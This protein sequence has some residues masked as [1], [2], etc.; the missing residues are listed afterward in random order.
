[1]AVSVML[2]QV[3]ENGYRATALVPTPLVAEAPTRDEAVDRI[4]A[5]ISERLSHAELIR[6]E[7]PLA[8]EPNPWLDMAGTWREHPDV[9]EVVE[10]INA[11]RHEVDA[12]PDWL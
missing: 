2:E 6:L 8:T 1:M 5:L 4:R 10:N 3:V 9:D 11:Y 7:V 12:D